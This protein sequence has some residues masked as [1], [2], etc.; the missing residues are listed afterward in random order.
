MNKRSACIGGLWLLMGGSALADYEYEQPW[1]ERSQEQLRRQRGEHP[2]QRWGEANPP[3]DGFREQDSQQ[4]QHQRQN[5]YQNEYGQGGQG[6][7]GRYGQGQGRGRGR[8]R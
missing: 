5:Q 3:G 2:G 1:E 4:Y 8:G 7:G 6:G